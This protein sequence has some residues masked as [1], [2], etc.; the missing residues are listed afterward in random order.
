MLPKGLKNI[1][2][3]FLK[4]FVYLHIHSQLNVGHLQFIY[5]Q[6]C[7]ISRRQ[8]SEP[9]LLALQTEDEIIRQK[10]TWTSVSCST[11]RFF[12]YPIYL[13]AHVNNISQFE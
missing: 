7:W 11:I 1:Q 2:I 13:F 3:A 4:I 12:K 5:K 9:E 10:V 8:L 6:K